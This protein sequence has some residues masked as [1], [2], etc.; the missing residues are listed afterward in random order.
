MKSMNAASRAAIGTATAIA[1][2]ETG[3]VGELLLGASS[4]PVL[5]LPLDA[6]LLDVSSDCA[7]V[8]WTVG[9]SL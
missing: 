6:V 4:P 1:S 3:T 9:S 2:V 8:G 5:T 7:C